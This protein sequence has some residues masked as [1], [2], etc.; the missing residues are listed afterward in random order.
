LIGA[1]IHKSPMRVGLFLLLGLFLMGA[2]TAFAQVAMVVN[3]ANPVRDISL[4]KVQDIYLGNTVSWSDNL[5]IYPVSLKSKEDV[6]QTFFKKALQKKPNDMKRIWIRLMLSGEVS[7]PK[8]MGLASDVL[9]YV[10]SNEGAI[11]FVDLTYIDDRTHEH[12]QVISVEGSL[13]SQAGYLLGVE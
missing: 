1:R 9:D 8:V 2:Q 11:G 10:A 5:R 6:T 12:V 3:K 4:Q 13:P 7:P